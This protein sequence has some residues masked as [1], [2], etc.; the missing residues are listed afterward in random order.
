MDK[1]QEMIFRQSLQSL[2]IGLKQDSAA[3]TREKFDA[4]QAANNAK[5]TD[6][7]KIVF[8]EVIIPVQKDGVAASSALLQLQG[9]EDK[10]AKAPSGVI[11]GA[12]A[13]SVGALFGTE[14]NTALRELDRLQKSLLAQ[15]PRLPG[16]QSNFDA[17]NLEKAIGKLTDVKMTNEQRISLVKEL[18]LGFEKLANRAYAAELYWESNRKVLPE[19]LNQTRTIAKTGTVTSGENKGKTIIIILLYSNALIKSNCMPEIMALVIPHPKHS[20][21]KIFFIRQIVCCL[22]N[23][24]NGIRYKRQGNIMYADKSTIFLLL[25]EYIEEFIII[26]W[27][28]I[29]RSKKILHLI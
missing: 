16:S 9:V 7:Q 15:M 28:K 19:L 6:E 11:S 4:Q 12:L 22:L 1:Q 5:L 23:Q 26:K 2:M 3:M 17:Q 18:K 25:L 10:I 29:R 21:P 20:T 27:M 8:K 14:S 13:N 24:S